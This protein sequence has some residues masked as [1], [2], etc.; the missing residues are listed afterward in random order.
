MNCSIIII[1]E[2][3][4]LGVFIL[5][6]FRMADSGSGDPGSRR[7]PTPGGS[8]RGPLAGRRPPSAISPGRLPSMRSRDLTLGGVK[9][10]MQRLGLLL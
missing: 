5:H 9:K 10:V 6:Q 8:T 3:L 1:S 4:K 2:S 7:A